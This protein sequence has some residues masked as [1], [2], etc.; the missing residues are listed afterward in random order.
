MFIFVIDSVFYTKLYDFGTE[1]KPAGTRLF[2][3]F[4]L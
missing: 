2:F 3:P 1:T 4:S